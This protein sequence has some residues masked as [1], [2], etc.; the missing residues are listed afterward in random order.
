MQDEAHRSHT[1][2]FR[3]PSAAAAAEAVHALAARGV[4]VDCRRG[5]L[6]IGFGPNH[7][8]ADVAALL[9]ALRS[10]APSAA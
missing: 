5:H 4:Q 6:R 1:L 2:V 7:S 9:S 8:A 10:A 3:L